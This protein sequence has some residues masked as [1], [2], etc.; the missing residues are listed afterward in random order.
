MSEA[1][2]GQQMSQELMWNKGEEGEG[3]HFLWMEVTSK[4]NLECVHCYSDSGPDRPL[5]ESMTHGDWEEALRQAASLGCRR[6][7][8]TGGEP[9][10]YPRLPDLLE[11][12]RAL[13]YEFVEVYT[14]GMILTDVLKTSFLRHKVNLAFSLYA[15]D[16][17]THEGVTRRRGSFEGTLSNIQWALRSRLPVRVAAIET[18]L[19]TGQTEAACRMLRSMG[20]E[21][22]GDETM[23]RIGRGAERAIST[24][25]QELCGHCWKGKLCLTASGDIFPCVFSRFC[26][27]GTFHQGLTTV[28]NSLGLRSFRDTVRGMVQPSDSALKSTFCKPLKPP[29]PCKPTKPP[30]PCKPTE[31]PE[32]C[33]PTKPPEPCK[34]TK[35]PEPCKPTE[36]PEPCK[37]TKPPEPCKPTEPP[38]PCK[39]SEPPWPWK[40]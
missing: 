19:N 17:G 27:V 34:P 28:V 40:N 10:L 8:F 31:P 4:C 25:F 23:R 36:P 33:K 37:P 12:A 9:T 32:P 11:T 18:P 15:A 14:N 6:V 2:A 20:V 1:A 13:S 22:V 39:P 16:A 26:Q 21:S 5:Q 7:Q 38:E 24:P 35:P 3:L 29:E 30:E